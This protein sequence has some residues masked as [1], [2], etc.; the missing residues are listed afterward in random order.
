[1]VPRRNSDRALT[2]PFSRCVAT[3]LPSESATREKI[4]VQH[5]NQ[6]AKLSLNGPACLR[7]SLA[8]LRRLSRGRAPSLPLSL[9][10][11]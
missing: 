7:Q 11:R 9:S 1:M 8:G 2:S 3:A 5:A 6:V 4:V 10:F